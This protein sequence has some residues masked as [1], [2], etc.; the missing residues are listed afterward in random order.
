MQKWYLNN[1]DKCVKKKYVHSINDNIKIETFIKLGT[2]TSSF[3]TVL[4][5]LFLR[6]VSTFP[7]FSFM[8]F[9]SYQLRIM[10]RIIITGIQIITDKLT[11]LVLRAKKIGKFILQKLAKWDAHV[12]YIWNDV[13]Q[14]KIYHQNF[15]IQFYRVSIFLNQIWVC[16]HVALI[17]ITYCIIAGAISSI[18][19][20]FF[21]FCELIARAF[22]WAK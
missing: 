19:S 22:R 4:Q 21:T 20:E 3:K 8:W 13:K 11:E 10:L 12:D 15:S 5:F 6:H 16:S 9:D 14:K 2:F 7:K 18:F 17:R 1:L